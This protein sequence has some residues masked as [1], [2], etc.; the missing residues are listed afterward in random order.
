MSSE[1]RWDERR[2]RLEEST[3]QN[4]GARTV[5]IEHMTPGTMV[6]PHYHNR[7]SETFDLIKGSI[8]V[9][10]AHEPDLQKLEA[11]I[12]ELEIGR[13]VTVKPKQYHQYKVGPDSENVLRCIITPGDEDFERLLMILNGLGRDGKLEEL[14]NSVVL[15]AVIMDLSD[16]HL[17]GPARDMLDGV[18]RDHSVEIQELKRSLLETYDNGQSLQELLTTRE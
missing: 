3:T 18:R 5:F 4:D 17:I 6:P 2:F 14:G 12:Q 9:F 11:S 1:R 7:F 13:K 16:A 15:M 8:S 10:A